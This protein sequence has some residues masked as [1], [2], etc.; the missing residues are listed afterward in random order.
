MAASL[1]PLQD[2]LADVGFLMQDAL[3]LC[4]RDLDEFS[5]L[6]AFLTADF[7][8]RFLLDAE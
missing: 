1:G 6:F 4:S 8:I 2:D 5:G 7:L 3:P